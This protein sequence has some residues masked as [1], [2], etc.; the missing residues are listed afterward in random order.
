[1]KS[2]TRKPSR[3][4]RFVRV[5][6]AGLTSI[7]TVAALSSGCLDRPVAEQEPATSNVFVTQ[8]R[9]T[10]VDKIDLLFMIDNSQSMADKQK[11]LAE[12]VPQ[13]VGRLLNP[14]CIDATTG[15]VTNAASPKD[16]CPAGDREFQPIGDVH[17][18]VVSSSLGGHG[19]AFCSAAYAEGYDASM[20]D[21]AN[22]LPSVRSGLV[23]F[24]GQGFLAWDNSDQPAAGAISDLATME[25]SFRDHVVAAGE[26]GCG[27]EASLESWYRFLIDPVPFDRMIAGEGTA[28]ATKSPELDQT[29]LAQRGAFLRSDSLVAVIMLS[30]ENDCSIIDGGLGFL[31]S[32]FQLSGAT[33]QM[34]R[35]TTACDSNPNDIC[36]QSCASQ[37]WP[38]G[39]DKAAL[40]P[41]GDVMTAEEDAS[42]LRCFDQKRR[43]GL[44]LLYPTSRYSVGLQAPTLCP[45]STFPDSDCNCTEANR[46]GT[47]C[48][49]G[50]AVTNPLYQNQDSILGRDASLVFLAGIVGVPW[51]DIATTETLNSPNELR[52]K[53]A[54]EIDWAWILGDPDNHVPAGNPLMHESP[55]PRV[56]DGIAAP[57]SALPTANPVN[58]HEWNPAG[59]DL[60]YACIF[61]LQ[62]SVDC[63]NVLPGKNCDC[64]AT[65][66]EGAG[67]LDD[68]I[69]AKKPLCQNAQSGDYSTVQTFA[70][71][72]PGLRELEVLRDYGENSIVASVCP[73]VQSG[74]EKT[75]PNYGYNPAVSAIV[76]RLKEKLG[77]RCLP[78]RLDVDDDGLVQC[79]VV[80]AKTTGLACTCE[81]PGRVDLSDKPGLVAA[82][83]TA[84]KGTNCETG[85]EGSPV[86]SDVCLCGIHQYS[87]AD[88]AADRDLCLQSASDAPGV[89]TPGYC[90][91]DAMDPNPDPATTTNVGNPL[92]V[93]NCEA[94]QKR[95]LRFVGADTPARGSVTFIACSGERI[96]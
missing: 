96:R 93:A 43:F 1:M 57:D 69:A 83:R 70:K 78:R 18:G 94:S 32:T 33:F 92:L 85:I 84:L 12:A 75:D 50:P 91:I 67:P 51:Q 47:S 39:C 61:P 95:L 76:D 4:T 71:A 16:N 58:G 63:A 6:I 82:V 88:N 72:Y 68:I 77:G 38:A 66:R 3:A 9:Q 52:Y 87:S 59:R 80:E 14:P 7:V 21:M 54:T 28:P 64:L 56:G 17:I 65:T 34:R 22:L 25:T 48:D 24:N 89:S 26:V 29:I 81:Q 10:A 55:L 5:G 31:V 27:F 90:Y 44:D 23:D 42:N 40:C 20:E 2:E 36:C 37:S 53:R 86:C 73:K 60:Q 45:D 46:L 13:L 41:N 11:L 8:F 30:D 15:A 79:E 62:E 49:P 74:V 19:G 35:G